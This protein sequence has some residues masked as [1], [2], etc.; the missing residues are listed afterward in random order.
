M[1]VLLLKMTD[2]DILKIDKDILDAFQAEEDNVKK[3]EKNLADIE[4]CMKIKDLDSHVYNDLQK[5]KEQFEIQ[6]KMIQT[7]ERVNFYIAESQEI[8]STYKNL[9]DTPMKLSFIGKKIK[10]SKEKDESINQYITVANKYLVKK[11]P[12]ITCDENIK[13]KKNKIVCDHCKN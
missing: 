4:A 8:L 1:I 7:K 9:L 13:L 3:Y 11:L 6:L 2:I 10:S 5:K 12:Y